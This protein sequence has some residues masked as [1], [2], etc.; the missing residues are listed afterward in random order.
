MIAALNSNSSKR[1][2]RPRPSGRPGRTRASRTSSAGMRT[3]VSRAALERA[4][5]LRSSLPPPTAFASRSLRPP[6][7]NTAHSDMT[8]AVVDAL[9]GGVAA[10]VV[11]EAGF[12]AAWGFLGPTTSSCFCAAGFRGPS[13]P[14]CFAPQ[15]SADPLLLAALRRRLPRD[16]RPQAAFSAG[17]SVRARR[18]AAL[19]ANQKKSGVV[20]RNG[21]DC[22]SRRTIHKLRAA[23]D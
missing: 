4:P 17:S 16:Q 11:A 15:A 12:L 9:A 20:L 21:H 10:G 1:R 18:C 22:P 7:H 5:I 13:T 6:A 2:G 8:G 19:S 14:S 3:R 23:H